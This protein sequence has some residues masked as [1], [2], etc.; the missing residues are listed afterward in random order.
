LVPRR[1]LAVGSQF[2]RSQFALSKIE[3]SLSNAAA[4]IIWQQNNLARQLLVQNAVRDKVDQH[5][6]VTAA[7]S[8]IN[9]QIR[10]AIMRW[11]TVC[12]HASLPHGHTIC[13]DNIAPKKVTKRL[14]WTRIM[15]YR[16]R[17][18]EADKKQYELPPSIEHQG[19]SVQHRTQRI[20]QSGSNDGRRAIARKKAE[21]GSKETQPSQKLHSLQI[22]KSYI[23]RIKL[24]G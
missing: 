8:R 17:P 4:Q 14:P 9:T 24:S 2:A 11:H 23:P 1:V 18:K 6:A 13:S 12:P 16:L 7:A 5:A 3:S 20:K 10:A 22:T 15:V 19:S 21:G